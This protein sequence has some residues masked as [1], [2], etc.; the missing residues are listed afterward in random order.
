M[1]YCKKCGVE[2]NTGD[3]F[4]SSC[5]TSVNENANNVTSQPINLTESKQKTEEKPNSN[6]STNRLIKNIGVGLGFLVFIVAIIVSA[7][8]GNSTFIELISYIMLIISACTIKRRNGDAIDFIICGTSGILTIVL[9]FLLKN[10]SM[11]QLCGGVVLVI[12][13]INYVTGLNK[14]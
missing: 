11:A 14:K 2:L 7:T 12:A 9:S 1:A 6:T 5:G 10:G 8:G 3:T 13:I 4:C